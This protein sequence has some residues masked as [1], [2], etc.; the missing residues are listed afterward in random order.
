VERPTVYPVYT[1]LRPPPKI[2]DKPDG[3][4]T[5]QFQARPEPG[6]VPMSPKKIGRRSRNRIKRSNS[7][8]IA[9]QAVTSV[10]PSPS[11]VLSSPASSKRQAASPLQELTESVPQQT[12]KYLLQASEGLES[13]E[14]IVGVY[15]ELE[16]ADE[17]AK[18]Y[19]GIWELGRA[20]L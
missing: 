10:T 12:F 20:R 2:I 15:S 13:S 7:A 18:E 11:Q 5:Y 9:T 8:P 4:K 14:R 1:P 6:A 16:R 19:V 17:R 3:G